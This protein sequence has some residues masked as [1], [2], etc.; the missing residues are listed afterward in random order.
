MGLLTS[1]I[2]NLFGKTEKRIFLFGLDA[3]GKTSIL[4]KLSLNK[5]IQ[6]IPTIGFN[7]EEVHYKKITFNIWDI[8][9]GKEIRRLWHVYCEKM[10][11][12]VIAI[13]TAD[14]SRIACE[15]M[16]CGDCLKEYVHF[17]LQ[18]KEAGNI[19]L[20]IYANKQ[21]LSGAVGPEYI[22]EKLELDRVCAERSWHI[23]P[24]SALTGDG[25]LDGLEW[26]TN[27]FAS[28]RK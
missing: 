26:L 16:G 25:L 14:V 21:D 5:F 7:T 6:T 27:E 2:K 22:R 10:D 20:L 28:K 3:A 11:A 24:C 18:Q 13:D 17:L 1:K 4:Y 23:Q 9:G 12:L 8:G 19:P 15:T